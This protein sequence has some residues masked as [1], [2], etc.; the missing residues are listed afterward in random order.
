MEAGREL[1][2]G[3]YVMFAIP[4]AAFNERFGDRCGPL[5]LAH[6]A[7]LEI[8]PVRS[9]SGGMGRAVTVHHASIVAARVESVP[10]H[11]YLLSSVTIHRGYVVCELDPLWRPMP[12]PW[13]DEALRVL[14]RER[15]LGGAG[16]RPYLGF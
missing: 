9:H 2:A 16:F 4:T 3:F 14:G 12:A 1:A 11:D 7:F 13:T 5:G 6:S 10:L 15:Q 8:G